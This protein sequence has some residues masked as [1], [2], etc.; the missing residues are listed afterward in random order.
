MADYVPQIAS[1]IVFNQP[2]ADSIAK[3]L[4][5][6]LLDPMRRLVNSFLLDGLKAVCQFEGF[7]LANRTEADSGKGMKLKASQ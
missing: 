2:L 3:R 6:K 5:N 1:R 4:L 7:N